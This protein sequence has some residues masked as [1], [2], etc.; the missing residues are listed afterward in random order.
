VIVG[1]EG[2]GVTMGADGEKIDVGGT[3]EF[4]LS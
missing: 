2:V 3:Y 4:G 1:I